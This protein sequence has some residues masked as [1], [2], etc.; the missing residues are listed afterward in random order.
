MIKAKNFEYNTNAVSE[1]S[2][3]THIELYREY[4]EKT[5]EILQQLKDEPQHEKAHK[6]YSCH[7]SCKK[8]LSY[9]LNSVVLHEMYFKNLGK[10]EGEPSSAFKQLANDFGY[11][12]NDFIATAKSA[13]GWCV[14]VF[15]QRTNKLC[16]ILLD[17]YDTGVLMNMFPILV[18]DMYEHAYFAE[19]ANN[20]EEYIQRFMKNVNWNVANKRTESLL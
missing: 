16:N 12:K 4:V 7:R 3:K 11:W 20:R 15:E 13:R 14:S 10:G 18:I 5:N 19:H 17:S 1:K 2:H 8:E 6:N 9:N